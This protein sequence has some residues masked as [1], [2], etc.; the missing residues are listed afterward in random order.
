MAQV[1]IAEA[2]A[3]FAQLVARAEAGERIVITRHGQPVAQVSALPTT[4][5]RSSCWCWWR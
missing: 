2:K 4:P 5:K 3:G 1:S